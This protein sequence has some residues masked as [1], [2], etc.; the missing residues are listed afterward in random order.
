[1]TTEKTII[2]T[3]VDHFLISTFENQLLLIFLDD[4]EARSIWKE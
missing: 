1:M 3:S 4:Q 2:D